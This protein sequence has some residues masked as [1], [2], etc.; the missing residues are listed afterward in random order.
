MTAAPESGELPRARA[1]GG[2]P[3]PPACFWPHRRP[4]AARHTDERTRCDACGGL[5]HVRPASR[6]TASALDTTGRTRC[7]ASGGLERVRRAAT[8]AAG[9]TT[10]VGQSDRGE[11]TQCGRTHALQRVRWA[12]TR[13]SSQPDH[14]QRTPY[15][16]AHALQRVRRTGARASGRRARAQG[17]PRALRGPARPAVMVPWVRRGWPAAKV[18]AGDGGPG[19]TVPPGAGWAPRSAGCSLARRPGVSCPGSV[20]SRRGPWPPG[21][22]CARPWAGGS[23][24]SGRRPERGTGWRSSCARS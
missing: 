4:G 22:R 2:L 10:C 12:G 17:R 5:Q 18:P 20:G 8:R 21:G 3:G 1:G 23:R 15:D 11:R 13:A 7:D 16:R 9:W 6:A 24:R 14:G 19:A